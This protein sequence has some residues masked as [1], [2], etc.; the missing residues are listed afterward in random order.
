M[1]SR[2]FGFSVKICLFGWENNKRR[3]KERKDLMVQFMTSGD[4]RS[5]QETAAC[6]DKPPVKLEIED[7]LEDEHGPVSKRPKASP[8]F[9][10][11]FFRISFCLVAEKI[12]W[13]MEKVQS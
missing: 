12:S 2:D 5:E 9:Q 7:S 13:E 10:E 1:V 4:F 11:V 6:T 3:E 8:A